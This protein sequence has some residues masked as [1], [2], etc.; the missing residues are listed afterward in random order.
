MP[1]DRFTS[2][3]RNKYMQ[4][5][6]NADFCELYDW[7]E[8]V[9]QVHLMIEASKRAKPAIEGVVEALLQQFSG[10]ATLPFE[11]DTNKQAIGA[12]IKEILFDYGYIQYKSS[13]K[14]STKVASG[15]FKSG[16]QYEYV[17]GFEGKR[18]KTVIV[19]EKTEKKIIGSIDYFSADG[20]RDFAKKARLKKLRESNWGY[21]DGELSNE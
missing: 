4:Y 8:E 15:P 14:L 19:V 12:A 16:T 21:R 6:Q 9:D 3:Q 18:L 7:L 11:D 5:G 17:E 13:V 2:M 1:I 20:L 10:R